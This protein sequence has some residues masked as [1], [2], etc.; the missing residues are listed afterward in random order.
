MRYQYLVYGGCEFLILLVDSP[1]TEYRGY[2]GLILFLISRSAA[3]FFLLA[4]L[5]D[6]INNVHLL[7]LRECILEE[8]VFFVVRADGKDL[9]IEVLVNVIVNVAH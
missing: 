9:G 2:F 6:I 8:F 7:F 4:F 1:I 5:D 3:D